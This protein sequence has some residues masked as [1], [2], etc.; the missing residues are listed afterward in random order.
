MS[1]GAFVASHLPAAKGP[2]E[3]V[4]AFEFLEHMPS[5]E[6]FVAQAKNRMSAGGV[7]IGSVSHNEVVPLNDHL[8]HIRHYDTHSLQAMLD[9]QP[10]EH[11]HFYYMNEEGIHQDRSSGKTIIFVLTKDENKLICAKGH[12]PFKPLL[13]TEEPNELFF[14]AALFAMAGA[15]RA[16]IKGIPLATDRPGYIFW[17]PYQTIPKGS[18]EVDF[19][20]TLPDTPQDIALEPNYSLTLDIVDAQRQIPHFCQ[21]FTLAKLLKFPKAAIKMEFSDN[22]IEFR[23]LASTDAQSNSHPSSRGLLFK[24]VRLNRLSEEKVAALPAPETL[25]SRLAKANAQRDEVIAQRDELIAQRN[26]AIA[27]RDGANAQLHIVLTSRSWCVTKLLRFLV[28]WLRRLFGR[29]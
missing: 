1:A 4:I 13:P 7:F 29:S 9:I 25:L 6:T 5:P 12:I 23:A 26:K 10:D 15:T 18:W 27:Q 2:F 17:G 19:L 20:F 3:L 22:L 11:V 16:P 24:G 14:P 21:T 8:F 28:R